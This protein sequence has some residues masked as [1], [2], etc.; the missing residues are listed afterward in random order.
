MRTRTHAE[1]WFGSAVLLA[2]NV[3]AP[4]SEDLNLCDGHLDASD[5]GFTDVCGARTSEA[6]SPFV[7]IYAV[8]HAWRYFR[9]HADGR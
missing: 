2:A 3:I 8:L 1:D 9:H 5:R 7:K 4:V 6:S